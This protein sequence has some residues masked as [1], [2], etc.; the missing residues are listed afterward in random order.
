MPLFI[1]FLVFILGLAAGSFINSI[2]L[3]YNTGEKVT[4]GRSRCF[5]CGRKLSWKELIPLFSFIFLMRR[6]R[7]C[8]SKI[9]WQYPA[10][11]LLTGALFLSFFI[12]WSNEYGDRLGVL[13]F[14]LAVASLLVAITLYDLRHKIIPD[15]FSYALIAAVLLGNF[16]FFEMN[17]AGFFLSI[18]PAVF[19]F[20][21]WAVSQG[22]WMGLGDAKLMAGGGIFLGF[23]ACVWA[24]ILA[25]WIGA[26]FG[27][28][29]LL[30]SRRTTLKSEIPFGPFLAL[31]I[32]L[33]FLYA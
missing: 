33:S 9:S 30:V 13:V 3:R 24:A 14:F 17:I 1:F 15:A 7:N 10:A 28:V 32:V 8:R 2:V 11:E 23:P 27:I 25:F 6:C 18:I 20:L 31:G 12:K 22:R 16:I 19:L 29:L 26:L 21:L 4:R 5:N